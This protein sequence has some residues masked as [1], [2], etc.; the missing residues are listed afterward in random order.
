MS[1]IASLW[2]RSRQLCELPRCYVRSPSVGILQY[3]ERGIVR[4]LSTTLWL[5]TATAVL[6]LTACLSIIEGE[7]VS[8]DA[9][10][11]PAAERAVLLGRSQ[12]Y[13]AWG[14]DISIYAV[15][16]GLVTGVG[17]RKA[18]V[19]PGRHTI[20]VEHFV[21]LGGG[22]STGR[23]SFMLNLQPGHRY[24][25]RSVDNHARFFESRDQY[26]IDIEDISPG[27]KQ[28]L[29]RRLPCEIYPP[30][31]PAEAHSSQSSQRESPAW[32]MSASDPKRT[33]AVI[34]Y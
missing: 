2:N 5:A 17:L 21:F 33:V 24:Q 4:V 10:S 31:E 13:L 22:G 27:E 7:A 20:V 34:L 28:G 26:T 11:L 16:N 6:S 23:C 15:D 30:A 14:W 25:F 32:L 12:W 1:T 29:M 9:K 19:V 3:K 18:E 8:S